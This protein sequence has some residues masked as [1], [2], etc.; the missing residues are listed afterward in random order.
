M[1]TH[2]TRFF[3]ILRLGDRAQAVMLAYETD[4]VTPH[5]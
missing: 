3:L 1:K 2:V 5:R 4:L